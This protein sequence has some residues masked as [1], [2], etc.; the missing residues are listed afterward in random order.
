MNG[1]ERGS[2]IRVGMMVG[3]VALLLSAPTIASAAEP[4]ACVLGRHDGTPAPDALTLAE[5]ACEEL[6]RRK[7]SVMTRATTEEPDGE[8]WVVD[9]RTL[10]TTTY[11]SLTY[12]TSGMDAA[13]TEKLQLNRIEEGP[14][15]A[16]RLAEAYAS[17][18]SVASTARPGNLVGQDLGD[19]D[20]KRYGELMF[21][22]GLMG[23]IAPDLEMW[24]GAGLSLALAWEA[25]RYGV[26][27][28]FRMAGNSGDY[29]GFVGGLHLG[30]RYYFLDADF[31]PYVGLGMAYVGYSASEPYDWNMDGG[32]VEDQE[33]A[34]YVEPRSVDGSGLAAYLSAGVQ[35]LRSWR[36]RMHFDVRVE[37]PFFTL[38][39]VQTGK[40]TWQVPVSF[41]LAF[42]WQ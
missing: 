17:N 26:L 40:K 9:L 37:Q 31:S 23:V 14:D 12:F 3:A 21:G 33:A 22:A 13:W 16:V 10:G 1:A 11:L 41:N 38:E 29:D 35:G 30:G 4:A 2:V 5:L 19:G 42:F 25:D 34:P 27:T 18:R 36:S 20:P 6:K 39:S 28:E 8:R 24:G 7:V 15:A 32:P